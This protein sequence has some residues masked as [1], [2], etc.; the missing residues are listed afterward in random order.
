[1]FDVALPGC[2]PAPLASYLKAL[3]ILRLVAE[4]ADADARGWW[5]G[6]HFV[7]ASTLDADGLEALFLDRYAPTPIIAPWNGGSGFYAGDNRRGIEALAAA[8]SPRFAGYAAAIAS[9]ER[10]R[11]GLG[12]QASPK[13]EGKAG[14][15]ARLRGALPDD[16]LAWFDAAVVLGSDQ[17]LYPPLLGTGGNDGRLDFTNN[18]MQRLVELIDPETG[19]PLPGS[20]ALIGEALFGEPV[21]GLSDVAVGQFA[22]GA[23]GGPNASA[24]LTGDP[25][26]NP[27]DFVLMLEGAMVFAA[28]A[29]RRNEKADTAALSF[30]F[31][32][33]PTAAGSGHA[34]L[35]DEG[36]SRAE[37]WM[38]LWARPAGFAEVRGL[39]AEGRVTLGCRPVRGPLAE[40]RVTLG[41]RPVRDGLDFVRAVSSLGVDRGISRFQ[42]FGLMMRSGKAFLATPM[43]QVRVQRNARADLI[44]QLDEDGWLGS[45]RRL[46]RHS[47]APARLSGIGRRLDQAL[48][49]LATPDGKTATADAARV[50]AA[51]VALGDAVHHLAHSPKARE[52]VRFLPRL[53]QQ[54]AQAA[55]DASDEF[56]LAAAIAGLGAGSG[57]PSGAPPLLAHIA[58]VADRGGRWAETSQQRVVWGEGTLVD[59]LIR[60]LRRRL[61]DAERTGAADKPLAGKPGADLA[62]IAAFLSCDTDDD[63]IEALVRGLA[64]VKGI[65]LPKRT[66]PP[67]APPLPA[68]YA[69]LKPLF[70]PEAVL[71]AEHLL[72]AEIRLPL[73]ATLLGQVLSGDHR[74]IASAIRQAQARAR[75]AGLGRSFRGLG[76][77]GLDGRRL[78]AALLIPIRAGDVRRLV[79]IAYPAPEALPMPAQ[80]EGSVP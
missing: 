16:A 63:R 50:Q 32:V 36:S 20:A 65:W 38:P 60:V 29:T 12:L 57:E 80:Q 47:E 14:F 44:D 5:Q 77:A 46:A 49:D 45:F 51:L 76:A 13:N 62:A 75:I 22:P 53:D 68:A 40:G 72:G 9:A 31:T 67:T 52:A 26:V 71:R 56:R 55:D 64:L 48:F 17:P 66:F 11:D 24:G 43:T 28:A 15:L 34:V 59:A 61:I 39:L 58:P 19:R 41:H 37:L 35:K 23:A 73:P 33:R 10:V 1:M 27:W 69:A 30:P 25:L 8:Q 2:A 78:A 21:P 18:F 42:R 70:T 79:A 6:G 74:R 4:Q 7:L 54:W 3:G